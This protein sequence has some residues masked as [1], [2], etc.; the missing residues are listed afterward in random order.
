MALNRVVG[1]MTESTTALK[2][3]TGRQAQWHMPVIPA[4][5]EA[6]A[7]DRTFEVSPG[8]LV[9]TCLKGFKRVWM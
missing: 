7:E 8:N 4:T 1:N 5:R 2:K 6:E 3:F 9:R